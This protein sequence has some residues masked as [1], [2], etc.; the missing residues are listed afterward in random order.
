M[1]EVSKKIQILFSGMT[2]AESADYQL[3]EWVKGNSLHNPV[4][5]ECCP[6]FSCCCPDNK[7]DED[8]RIKFNNAH[9]MGDTKTSGAILGMALTGI[10]SEVRLNIHVTGENT[11]IN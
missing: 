3:S 2:E 7:M 8:L 6:D 9:K 5:D 1:T 4:R 10:T 11:T